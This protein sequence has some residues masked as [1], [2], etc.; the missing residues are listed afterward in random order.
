MKTRIVMG[1]LTLAAAGLLVA[2]QP[3]P[4]PHEAVLKDMLATLGDINKALKGITDEETATAARPPLRDAAKK[5]QALRK[6]ADA[7]K[8]PEK[9]EKDRLE[10]AYRVK[11]EEAL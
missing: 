4:S 9:D 3:Q 7:L 11:L 2:G 8:Q 5:L 1:A 10:T 6:R